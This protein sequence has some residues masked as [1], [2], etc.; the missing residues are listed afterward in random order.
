MYKLSKTQKR[1]NMKSFFA[2]IV[3]AF[4]I[5]GL[6]LLAA[7]IYEFAPWLGVFLL[8]VFFVVI[9]LELLSAIEMINYDLS[10]L[11]K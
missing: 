2:A 6:H 9:I 11:W 10:K 7:L 1:E 3:V 4:F 8:G 5:V